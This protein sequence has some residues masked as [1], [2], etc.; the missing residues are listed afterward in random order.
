MT[1]IQNDLRFVE[2]ESQ[3]IQFLVSATTAIILMAMD[4]TPTAM[5]S[6]DGDDKMGHPQISI[7]V[8]LSVAMAYT[9]TIVKNVTT[10]MLSQMMAVVLPVA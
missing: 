2:M 10:E 6:M 3:S 1:L 7:I 8:W 5:L 4:V 9:L